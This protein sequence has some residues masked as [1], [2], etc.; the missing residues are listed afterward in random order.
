MGLLGA[1]RMQLFPLSCPS[2]SAPMRIIAFVTDVGS[3]QRI[4]EHIRELT[5]PPPI[6]SARGPPHGK[7]DFDSREGADLSELLPEFE[8]D[9]KLSG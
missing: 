1:P 8:F 2:C 4:F 6:A 5:T 9:Q 7:E 3:I